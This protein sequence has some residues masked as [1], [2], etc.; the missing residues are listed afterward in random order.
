MPDCCEW[1]TFRSY[2]ILYVQKDPVYDEWFESDTQRELGQIFQG[3]SHM[4]EGLRGLDRKLDE[5][6]G[7]QERTLSLISAQQLA[8]AGSQP[9]PPGGQA[10]VP[11]M[12]QGAFIDTIRRQEVEMVF[13]NQ[14]QI[15]TNMR[16]IR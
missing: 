7:K 14:N 5:V 3:Q 10:G 9:P 12:Q 2:S 1:W 4:L 8:P 13:S 16:E 15:I 11:P 6:I